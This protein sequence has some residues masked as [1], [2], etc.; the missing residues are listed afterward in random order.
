MN[1]ILNLLLIT[2][3]LSACSLNKNSKFWTSDKLEELEKKEFQKI[4]DDK[5]PLIQ[6][7][8]TN[9]NL[10]LGSNLTKTILKL[11]LK[12]LDMVLN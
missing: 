11:E 1:K 9:I 2:L 5:K 7:F 10:N 4:F 12:K 8:N 3:F 6:E